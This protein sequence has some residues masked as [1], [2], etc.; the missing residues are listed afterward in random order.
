[1]KKVI[2][3]S[4]SD[5]VAI[6]I[7]RTWPIIF[8]NMLKIFKLTCHLS[9]CNYSYML[10]AQTTY[11]VKSIWDFFPFISKDGIFD[12]YFSYSFFSF[13]FFFVNNL[14]I[15]HLFILIWD[16]RSWV[17]TKKHIHT[18]TKK[19]N[20]LSLQHKRSYMAMNA[21]PYKCSSVLWIAFQLP[22]CQMMIWELNFSPITFSPPHASYLKCYCS[23]NTSLNPLFLQLISHWEVLE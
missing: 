13:F 17:A 14:F 6:G 22:A 2:H 9:E 3:N 23:V 15:F 1:M 11:R 5:Q 12:N 8:F 4:Q 7:Y 10:T 21:F 18:H 19:T 20:L 16:G